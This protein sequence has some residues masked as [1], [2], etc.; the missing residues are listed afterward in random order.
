LCLDQRLR[1]FD[2]LVSCAAPSTT[3]WLMLG[4]NNGGGWAGLA[5]VP[6]IGLGWGGAALFQALAAPRQR[7]QSTSTYSPGKPVYGAL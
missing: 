2:A 1:T 7:W 3:L 5:V 6:I 4:F